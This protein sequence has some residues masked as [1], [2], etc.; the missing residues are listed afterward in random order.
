MGGMIEKYFTKDSTAFEVPEL[1]WNYIHEE[2][3]MTTEKKV[4]AWAEARN[5][6]K[7]STPQNQMV[8][9]MEEVG[10][11]AA[12]IARN[13]QDEIDDSIGDIR[14]V[15]TIIA[16]MHKK[17]SEECYNSAY[18]VIKDRK[19]RMIAGVFVKEEDL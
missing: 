2:N 16:A 9:L 6:I 19:G 5:L 4:I 11:L 12:A 8:K 13:K 15:L 18:E 3:D 1:N 10:E 7:G 14:V 17:T